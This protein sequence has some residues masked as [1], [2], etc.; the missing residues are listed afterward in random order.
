MATTPLTNPLHRRGC[1][2]PGRTPEG[3]AIVTPPPEARSFEHLVLDFLAYLEFERGLSPPRRGKRPLPSP[4]CS[5]PPLPSSWGGG[6]R[7]PRWRPTAGPCSSPAASW[8]GGARPPSPPP[9]PPS[10]AG[11][12]RW[13]PATDGRPPRPRP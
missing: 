6:C 8:G 11:P 7:A 2:A 4:L 12:P 10:P 9:A 13:L 1:D 3:M 5:T